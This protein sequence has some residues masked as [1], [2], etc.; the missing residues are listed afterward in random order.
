MELRNGSKKKK[1]RSYG[2]GLST[3]QTSSGVSRCVSTQEVYYKR[4]PQHIFFFNR[5][6]RHC[7]LSCAL[8]L[9]FLLKEQKHD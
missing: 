2:S 8:L 7:T 9:F 3:H 1:K 4:Q 5:L 6:R